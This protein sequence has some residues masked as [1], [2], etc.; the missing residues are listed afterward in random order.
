MGAVSANNCFQ[1]RGSYFGAQSHPKG[2][3]HAAQGDVLEIKF[4][5]PA[6]IALYRF[7]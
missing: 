6:Q 7:L 4:V 2:G 3:A 5:D 1:M